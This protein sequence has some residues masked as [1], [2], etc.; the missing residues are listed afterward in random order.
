ME[1]PSSDSTKRMDDSGEKF[2]IRSHRCV[3][4]VE[5]QKLGFRCANL[6]DM[7]HKK[8]EEICKIKTLGMSRQGPG[9]LGPLILKTFDLF[10]YV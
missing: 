2:I 5:T 4:G 10:L 6:Q 1:H 7:V 8:T 3:C 9:C